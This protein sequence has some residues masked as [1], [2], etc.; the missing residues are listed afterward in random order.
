M[1]RIRDSPRIE[2]IIQQM[3][4]DLDEEL[5]SLVNVDEYS[6]F[7]TDKRKVE[8]RAGRTALAEALENWGFDSS[9]LEVIRDK[10][11][12]PSLKWI[13]GVFK[14]QALPAISIGHAEG[15]AIIALIESG[16]WVGIDG[17]SKGRGIAENAF[18][19]FCKGDELH[20]LKANP[21]E[22]IRLWTSKEAVQ[23][24]M[25]LGMSLNPRSISISQSKSNQ[26]LS[27]EG[28]KIQ[29]ETFQQDNFQIGLAWRVAGSQLRSQEDEIL[30]ATRE[31]MRDEAGNL[32]FDV[33]CHA[34]RD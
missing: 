7:K 4:V 8:H 3:N 18:A 11:R 2:I 26:E 32:I 28:M 34:R 29:L 10:N 16:W 12:A 15:Y 24:A 30:D 27:I 31:A 20:W 9:Q 14:N 33:T 1:I 23:K 25:H 13:Q 17:E 22:A 5:P 21:S 19:E 6:T